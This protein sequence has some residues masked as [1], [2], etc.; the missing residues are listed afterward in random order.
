MRSTILFTLILV[1]AGCTESSAVD[2]LPC[3]CAPQWKCCTGVCVPQ[4]EPC[5]EECV[6]DCDDGQARCIDEAIQVCETQPDGCWKWSVP[7]SCDPGLFCVEGVC[8]GGDA[9]TDTDADSDADSDTDTDSDSDS[10]T[11]SDSDSDTDS[12]ADS[13][14][15]T[16]SGIVEEQW[17]KLDLN[18]ASVDGNYG[19]AVALSGDYAFIG[20]PGEDVPY[21][22]SGVV[23]VYKRARNNS[24]YLV[25]RLGRG[26]SDLPL[27][28]SSHFGR[29]L[30]ASGDLLVVG[31]KNWSSTNGTIFI[32]E[33]SGDTWH[34]SARLSGGALD[35]EDLFGTTLATN[36]EVVLAGVAGE[37]GGIYLFHKLDGVWQQLQLIDHL[38]TIGYY[39]HAMRVAIDG[40][41][42]VISYPFEDPSDGANGQAWILESEGETWQVT[43]ELVPDHPHQTFG[44]AVDILGSRVII[45]SSQE[46]A[47]ARIFE[48]QD[49][50]WQQTYA[51]WPKRGSHSP[52]YNFDL[53]VRLT[54]DRAFIGI[55]GRESGDRPGEVR[56]IEYQDGTWDEVGSA[57]VCGHEAGDRFGAS[58]AAAERTVIIGAPEFSGEG[59]HAGAAYALDSLD[60]G[61]QQARRLD[62]NES[63]YQAYLGLVLDV[64]DNRLMAAAPYASYTD[65]QS[66]AV[67]IWE[68]VSRVRGGWQRTNTIV[69]HRDLAHQHLFGTDLAFAGDRAIISATNPATVY[70]FEERD[71]VTWRE[72]S[73][74]TSGDISGWFPASSGVAIAG[75]LAVAKGFYHSGSDWWG[76]AYLFERQDDQWIPVH[77]LIPPVQ[78]PLNYPRAWFGG[79]ALS[80]EMVVLGWLYGNMAFV[81]QRTE[82]G[83][84]EPFLLQPDD[85]SEGDRFGTGT[86]VSGDL[87]AVSANGREITPEERGVVY[88]YRQEAGELVQLARV[89]MSIGEE[90]W[91]FGHAVDLRDNTLLASGLWSVGDQF[92]HNGV[93]LFEVDT[94]SWS[95]TKRWSLDIPGESTYFGHRVGLGDGFAAISAPYTGDLH[96]PK[97]GAIHVIDWTSPK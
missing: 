44:H 25:D 40:N 47:K 97:S 67:H 12:D 41:R 4:S 58:V 28:S 66:G 80:D 69:P 93:G 89:S 45:G 60:D 71:S 2:P 53:A 26:Y 30:A 38:Y 15:D 86:A 10:D 68:K 50:K 64:S 74:Y 3:P 65:Y 6:S 56:V 70:F 96:Y 13:D 72:I 5:P 61:C 34:F 59:H 31:D 16:D 43:A 39:D 32:F 20:V 75:D 81:A 24:W 63:Q 77:H 9:D 76:S 94:A 33:R 14:S 7:R 55:P 62:A 83:W 36:G 91:G 37:T 95:E 27:P 92:E 42:A 52:T 57:L 84:G 78:V 17:F 79:V 22:N 88:L 90:N 23:Y 49:G 48:E 1:F 35:G 18:D 46:G 11:D 82:D 54:G 87:V 85:L 21:D 8:T 29:A 51:Y 19:K 73:Q